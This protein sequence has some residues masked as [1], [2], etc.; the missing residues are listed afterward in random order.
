M[1]PP[2]LHSRARRV[3]VFTGA[4]ISGDAPSSLPRGFGL[5]DCLVEAMYAAAV[6][7]PAAAHLLTP[8]H[9][10]ELLKSGRKLEV[11]LGRLWGT[12][13]DDALG[14]LLSLAVDLPNR[15]HLLAALHLASGGTH[16]TMNLDVAIEVAYD[17]VT[18][19]RQLPPNAPAVF[20]DALEEWRRLAPPGAA[21]LRVVAARE[22]FDAWAADGSPPALLKL[23][24][25]LSRDQTGLID[26][27]VVDVEEL[28]QL[29]PG[30]AAALARVA[31]ADELVVT[32][33]SGG[34]PDVHTPLIASAPV[35]ADVAPGGTAWSCRTT[36]RCDVTRWPA[37]SSCAWEIPAVSP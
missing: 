9:R 34:D 24:G 6:R 35:G 23:H 28:G 22:E 4:G 17:L 33:Y 21:P 8:A 30:R 20:Y 25:S 37:A 31:E 5:R 27:V 14:C 32:G 10:E 3:V 11:V 19:R 12:I 18:G 29:P 2:D 26:V 1:I 15:A 13:G 16:L 7:S 36:R